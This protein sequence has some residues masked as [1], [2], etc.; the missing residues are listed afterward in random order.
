MLKP[1]KIGNISIKH[2]IILAPMSNVTDFPFRYLANK[3]G[4]EV[5]VS[6]M[7]ADFAI[8]KQSKKTLARAQK[9]DNTN[10]IIQLVGSRPELMAEC[11]KII[12]DTGAE[13]IDIN[14]GCPCRKITGNLAGAALMKD[15][16]LAINVIDSVIK[17]VKIPV[18]IKIRM[19]WDYQNL[20]APYIAKI[21]EDLGV[22]MITIHGRTRSQMYSGKADWAFINKIKKEVKI[23]VIANGDIKNV[24]DIEKSL[25]ESEADGV[26]IGRANYGKPWLIGDLIK[27][28]FYNKQIPE[29]S[30]KKIGEILLEHYDL[31]LEYYG[32]ESGIFNARKHIIWYSSGIQNASTFRQQINQC[33]NHKEVIKIIKDFFNN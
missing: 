5:T 22:Q 15:E 24:E 8:I 19:G 12:E 25:Q 2:P 14:L 30:I 10:T 33:K 7:V 6:E 16:K 18:T 3:M 4:A 9:K 28:F 31:I 20:N 1:L 23:P 21:S 11:A 27:Q 17:A 29:I 13:A 26:M 32:I